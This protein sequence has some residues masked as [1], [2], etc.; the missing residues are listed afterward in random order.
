MVV[1]DGIWNL[2][3]SG[4]GRR[5]SPFLV[6]FCDDTAPNRPRDDVV[7]RHASA[8]RGL[9][10]RF[11]GGSLTGTRRAH[12]SGSGTG[13]PLYQVW[14]AIWHGPALL[15]HFGIASL[16]PGAPLRVRPSPQRW[17]VLDSNG[18]VVGELSL[19]FQPPPVCAAPPPRLSQSSNG[20]GSIRRRSTVGLPMQYLG[21]VVAELVFEL[22]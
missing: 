16:S 5:H 4:G 13:P 21:V 1:P 2:I 11:P 12:A 14:P 15:L 17:G 9:A 22:A 8:P 10:L 6:Q 20:T 3:G 7:P 18:A 19:D